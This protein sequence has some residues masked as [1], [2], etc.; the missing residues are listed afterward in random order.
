M[1]STNKKFKLDQLFVISRLKYFLFASMLGLSACGGGGGSS[2]PAVAPS[3]QGSQGASTI[4]ISGIAAKSIALSGASIIASNAT[5]NLGA[6]VT[7]GAD[8]AYSITIPA[9]AQV[10]I[11]LTASV[12]APSGEKESYSTVIVD[13]ANTTA[14]ITHITN[15]IAALLSSNGNPDQLAADITKG[16]SIT[17]AN[18]T[19]KTQAIQNLLKTATDVLGVSSIDPIKSSFVLNGQG[20]NKF[21]ASINVAIT[22]TATTSNIEIGLRSKALSASSQPIAAQFASNQPTL[23]TLPAVQAADFMADGT[24]AKLAQLMTDMQNCY[25]LP[26]GSRIASTPSG[27]TVVNGAAADITA[28]QCRAIFMSNDPSQYR[29]SGSIVGRNI[30]SGGS[31]ALMFEASSTGAKFDSAEYLYTTL[32][33]GDIG[34]AFRETYPSNVTPVFSVNTVRLDPT[35]QKLK[36]IGDQFIYNGRVRTFAQNRE[37][38]VLGLSQWNYI[39]TGYTINVDDVFRPDGSDLFKKVE[40]T[41]PNNIVYILEPSNSTT[42]MNFVG[43]GPSNFLRLKSEFKDTSKTGSVPDRLTSEKNVSAYASPEYS[44]AAIAALPAEGIWTFSYF[45]STNTGT[46]PDAVQTYRTRAR[47]PTIAELRARQF[48]TVTA[49]TSNAW[50]QA[51]APSGVLNLS[52]TAPFNIAW[53]TPASALGPVN[54]TLVGTFITGVNITSP[55]PFPFT[56]RIDF[57]PT[58]NSTSFSCVRQN[59]DPYCKDGSNGGYK[60]GSEAT[61]LNLIGVDGVGR[62]F[63]T[64]YTFGTLTI[65]Q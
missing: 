3:S 31:F 12:I 45:F 34:F 1:P 26:L 21:L 11:I 50:S 13:K 58:V 25:A 47:A 30:P 64:F 32:P 36:F 63:S 35:D 17:Q 56:D 37:F 29:N 55:A 39:S 54:A 27:A 19:E 2:A 10:P 38:P 59:V 57:A 9:D 15:A 44:D 61:G 62:N 18:L 46:K 52:T 7:V 51:A 6:A 22:P 65:A 24:V 42:F 53:I 40:V 49:A 48:A 23:P 20:Y 41:A 28:A 43:Q 4:T 14:N 8:G 16:S 33:N 5:G 60:P